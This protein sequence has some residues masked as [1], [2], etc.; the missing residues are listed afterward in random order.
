MHQG[1][2]PPLSGQ[3][4]RVSGFA[5][6]GMHGPLLEKDPS[7]FET[8]CQTGLRGQKWNGEKTQGHSEISHGELL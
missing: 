6:P 2:G 8:G 1:V 3:L 7:I 5:V 4:K